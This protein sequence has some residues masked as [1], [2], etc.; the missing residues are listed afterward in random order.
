MTSPLTNGAIIRFVG[1]NR[2]K[3]GQLNTI[4]LI[5][6]PFIEN[7]N[8]FSDK[9][10]FNYSALEILVLTHSALLTIQIVTNF[11]AFASVTLI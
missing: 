11:D 4:V 6:F 1:R 5:L 8:M 7:L 3:D 2:I 10:Y 9:H